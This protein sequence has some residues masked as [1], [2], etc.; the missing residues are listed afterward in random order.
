[1]QRREANQLKTNLNMYSQNTHCF[2]LGNEINLLVKKNAYSVI[3]VFQAGVKTHRTHVHLSFNAK[4]NLEQ[5]KLH[6]L[7]YD[8]RK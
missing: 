1:M 5:A 2:F 4:I 7:Y 3:V 8:L 6:V